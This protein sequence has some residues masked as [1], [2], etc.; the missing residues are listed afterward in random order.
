MPPLNKAH[1]LDFYLQTM[2]PLNK[3]HILDYHLQTMPPL[4]KAHI[5]D[6]YLQTVAPLKN[7]Q[8]RMHTG[9]TVDYYLHTATTEQCTVISTACTEVLSSGCIASKQCTVQYAYRSKSEL[10]SSDCAATEQCTPHAPGS[11]G[12][13]LWAHSWMDIC[14]IQGYKDIYLAVKLKC[15]QELIWSWWCSIQTM[16]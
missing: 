14:D 10:L 4:N 13:L 12:G 1:I 8:Y 11:K 2:P 5:L 6:F 3:A 9:L 16:H 7:A 15:A